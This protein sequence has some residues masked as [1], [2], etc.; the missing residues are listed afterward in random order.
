[1]TFTDDDFDAALAQ[2]AAESYARKDETGKFRGILKETEGIKIWR[3][4]EGNHIFDIVPYK[5]GKHDPRLP[6][7]TPTYVLDIWVHYNVGATEDSFVCPARTYSAKKNPFH[8]NERC[9]ICEHQNE[10]R[11]ELERVDDEDQAKAL[12]DHANS[13][14]PKRRVLYNVLVLD[15]SA[16][17]EK[18]VQI[19]DVA[20]W[21][22]ER[23]L[24]ILS[25]K[26]RGPSGATVGGHIPFASAKTGKSVV[27]QKKGKGRNTEFIGHRF[28]DRQNYVIGLELLQAARC[29]DEEIVIPSYDDLYLSFHGAMPGDDKPIESKVVESK[30]VT[31]EDIPSNRVGEQTDVTGRK[32]LRTPIQEE[33]P[34]PAKEETTAPAQSFT[35]A[36]PSGGVFGKD[37]DK[38][39]GCRKCPDDTWQECAKLTELSDSQTQKSEPGRNIQP[40]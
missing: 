33:A 3:P 22:M 39:P 28:E 1:M 37:A 6:A 32:M 18:G 17:E 36:C 40:A 38:I 4:A 19:W 34:A 29:L 13:L 7:G 12:E 16:E 25:E 10:L 2:R 11:K 20:H 24:S 30:V 5:T 15:S 21:S 23:H 26:K 8:L 27:F 14:N 9:P 35:T 31:E